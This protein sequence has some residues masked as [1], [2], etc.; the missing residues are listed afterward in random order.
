MPG[1]NVNRYLLTI[2][3]SLPIYLSSDPTPTLV[4]WNVGQGQWATWISARGC[5]HFDMG[6]ERM[7]A[8]QYLRLC[9]DRPNIALF[10]HWDWDHIGLA[11][12]ARRL[13]PNLCVASYP[14]GPTSQKKRSYLNKIPECPARL[15]FGS[16]ILEQF[17]QNQ[18][19]LNFRGKV[20]N[21]LSRVFLVAK[22]ILIPGDAPQ[23]VEQGWNIKNLNAL[24]TTHLLLGHHGSKTSTSQFLLTKLKTLKQAIASA[25]KK[26]YGHPHLIVRKRLMDAGISLITTEEWGHL[27]FWLEPGSD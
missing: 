27:Y 4:I 13:L 26:R 9:S 16:G 6:G 18:K 25:R 11:S 1:P 17:S 5:F 21:D 22:K 12:R 24:H 7:V 2:F 10:S 20:P 19:P 3:F 14:N 15:T 23:R 8:E